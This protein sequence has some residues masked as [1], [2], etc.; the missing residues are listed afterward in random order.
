VGGEGLFG[1]GLV[2]LTALVVG[3]SGALVPGPLLTLV[4]AESAREGP[5]VGPLSMIGHALLEL[6]LLGG[7]A[8]GLTQVLAGN[9]VPALIALFGGAIMLWMGA[10]MLRDGLQNRVAAFPLGPSGLADAPS[11]AG[12]PG[13]DRTG[14]RT[15][16]GPLRRPWYRHVAQGALISASNPYWSLWWASIG[17]AYVV[18]A[19]AL[20]PWGVVAFFIGHISADFTWY[21]LVSYGVAYGRR[22]LSQRFYR[23]LIGFC[24]VF[25]LGLA[26]YFLQ[27]GMR[28]LL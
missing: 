2:F 7:L 17:A 14:R 13:V 19:A 8:L 6:V 28:G 24:G 10:G 12:A 18:S 4:V 16:A 27:W 23:A 25:L 26:G 22:F 11:G 20:G 1:L 15:E 3:Y 5:H 21:G 9:T